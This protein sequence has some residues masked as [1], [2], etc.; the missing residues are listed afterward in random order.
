MDGVR[1]R[2]L[3]ELAR[4]PIPF[5][6]ASPM[7]MTLMTTARAP[8]L[9]EFQ[10]TPEP[11]TIGRVA[12]GIAH[13]FNNL[14][15]VIAAHT[16]RLADGIGP[17]DPRHASVLAIRASA[18]R[19]ASITET[20]L[21]IDGR[22]ALAAAD[23]ADRVAGVAASL[24]RTF[25]HRLEVST[26][27]ARPVRAVCL[28]TAQLDSY[29]MTLTAHA[30]DDMP[31]EGAIAF[32]VGNVTIGAS[33]SQA[34][35]IVREGAYVSVEISWS[36]LPAASAEPGCHDVPRLPDRDR[37]DVEAVSAQVRDR[38]GC[39]WLDRDLHGVM[40]FTLLVPADI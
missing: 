16:E 8:R 26:T 19:A 28:D 15:T 31:G 32:R 7:A 21:A 39:L 13:D 34:P 20:L 22:R 25:G 17:A 12:G 40:T 38:G 36:A 30:V 29:L 1:R 27:V 6:T 14:L 24:R 23:L 2:R 37:G 3:K 9:I 35:A 10:R 5:S 11:E 18:A 33:G 4:W